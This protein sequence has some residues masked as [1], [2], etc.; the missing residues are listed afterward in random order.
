MAAVETGGVLTHELWQK[1]MPQ[2]GKDQGNSNPLAHSH[3]PAH[4]LSVGLVFPLDREPCSSIQCT[5]WQRLIDWATHFGCPQ[6]LPIGPSW[7]ICGL[8]KLVARGNISAGGCSLFRTFQQEMG[9]VFAEARTLSKWERR[10]I[11]PGLLPPFI[12]SLIHSFTHSLIHSFTH[13]FTPS[14]T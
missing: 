7:N 8:T 13:S 5:Q 11:V 3:N 12:H 2:R 14:L 4:F 10:E 9:F 1:A 6:T